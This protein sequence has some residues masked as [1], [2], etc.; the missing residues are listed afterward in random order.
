MALN[1]NLDET[2]M[3]GETN[4]DKGSG[5]VETEGENTLAEGEE[6]R[7]AAGTVDPITPN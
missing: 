6:V 4:D 7:F 5:N 3:S 1:N 2:E